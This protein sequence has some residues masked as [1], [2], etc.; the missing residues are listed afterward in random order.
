MSEFI[1][2]NENLMI[3]VEQILIHAITLIIVM[4]RC[5]ENLRL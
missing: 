5:L 2:T 3:I 4:T 1:S